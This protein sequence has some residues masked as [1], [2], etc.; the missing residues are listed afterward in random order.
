[1]SDTEPTFDT[2]DASGTERPADTGDAVTSSDLEGATPDGNDLGD[3]GQKALD[4]E[5]RSRRDAERQLKVARQELL[6]RER[7]DVA[8]ERGLP[9]PL[10]DRLV[11][12]TREELE[13]DADALAEALERPDRRQSRPHSTLLNPLTAGE[14][15]A[16]TSALAAAIRRRT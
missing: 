10:A 1:M 4:R 7:R 3:E 15:I 14:D 2:D 9:A 12:A 11:G 8:A 13:A 16:D 5:R 6:E